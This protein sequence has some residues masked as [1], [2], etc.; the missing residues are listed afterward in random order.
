M[1]MWGI[2]MGVEQRQQGPLVPSGP[3]RKLGDQ[4]H[5]LFSASPIF[6]LEWF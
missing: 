5:G 1:G 2:L 3:R 4:Q 6:E